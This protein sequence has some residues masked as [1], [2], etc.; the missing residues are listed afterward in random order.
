MQGAD[1][2]LTELEQKLADASGRFERMP[3]AMWLASTAIIESAGRL[4]DTLPSSLAERRDE[5]L[6]RARRARDDAGPRSSENDV[7][8]ITL[9]VELAEKRAVIERAVLAALAAVEA[10]RSAHP[11][12]C[13]TY[14]RLSSTPSDQPTNTTGRG[15][16]AINS[17]T[18]CP[19]RE[20]V[21]PSAGTSLS[22]CPRGSSAT[23]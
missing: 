15:R 13:V 9:W 1:Q 8:A 20:Y 11:P 22:P 7:S 2:Q 18:S 21:Y 10:H 17:A 6:V 12:D 23:T 4:G 5:L 16:R 19:R 14:A 3:G